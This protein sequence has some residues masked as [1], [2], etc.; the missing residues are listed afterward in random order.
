M[1]GLYDLEVTVHGSDAGPFTA[2][3]VTISA[4]R[5]IISQYL[6]AWGRCAPDQL[7]HGDGRELPAGGYRCDH[8]DYRIIIKHSGRA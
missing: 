4:A 3:S 7:L 5:Q 8:P 1:T 6:A 2:S